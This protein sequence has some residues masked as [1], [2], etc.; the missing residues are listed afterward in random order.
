MTLR[1][2]VVAFALVADAFAADVPQAVFEGNSM[3]PERRLEQALRQYDVTLNDDVTSADDAAFFLREFYF[4]HGFRDASVTYDFSPRRVVFQIDEGARVW[5][6]RVRFEGGEALTR[7]RI[8]AVFSA[9]VRQE[10]H[11]PFGRLAYVESATAAGADRVR[12]TFVSEGFLDAV[13]T[14][15]TEPSLARD[16]VDVLV[17]ID[18]GIRYGIRSVRVEGAPAR[19]D[20]ALE[21]VLSVFQN[22]PYRPGD[23][24]LV[25]MRAADFL[26]SHGF[27]FA[28]ATSEALHGSG[29]AVDIVVRTVPGEAFRIGKVTAEG[30]VRTR[31][32]SLLQR[33]GIRPGSVFNASAIES[34]ERRLWFSG[35]FS[36]V[37]L[38]P[39]PQPDGT[40][41]L[42][43]RVEEGRARQVAT[44][45][46]YSQWDRGFADVLF[47]DRNFLGTL[48]R[49]SLQGFVSQRSYGGIMTLTQPSLFGDET[50]GRFS[51]FAQ[52]RELPAYRAVQY[53]GL[54]GID[55][56]ANDKTLTGWGVNYE[57]R[58][59]TD[60][61]IFSGSEADTLENYRLGMVSFY[62]QLDRR[63][64]VL[65]PMRG[66]NLRYE[67]GVAS[68]ALAGD[69]SFFKATAL[70]T[71]YLP[72]R[73]VLPERPYV[74]F[75]M[76][77]H[78]AG[79]I[80]PF[81]NTSSIPVPERFFLGG[82]DSVRSFQLDGMAPRD[83]D[84]DPT[85][86]EIFFQVNVEYQHPV[87]Q[88]IFAAVFTD[89]GNLSS[90]VAGLAWSDTRVA[91]GAGL[92]LYTPLGT[93]RA[94]YAFN[95][96]RKDGDPV[97]NWQ[98]GLGFTF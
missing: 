24:M 97:G 22:K 92:R 64:D 6:G 98:F 62:Q 35:A 2:T 84:G 54:V 8:E 76:L 73:E 12:Q 5:L 7:D 78:R 17:T 13:V 51:V 4:E 40:V 53:G 61:E 83:R 55:A 49:F 15:T 52:R 72:L 96:V 50:E 43:L 25:R 57:W 23:E 41:N 21:K 67:L 48:N 63:N 81:G 77:N 39:A 20:A 85:G 88:G 42:H 31:P 1:Q 26:R 68:P 93:V 74:P 58:V 60:T 19:V 65:A 46:G 10:M 34:G 28:A 32:G 70:A 94:D 82:P 9:A 30:T 71:W 3:F 36:D 59:I 16:S 45:V 18:Q 56:R 79:V 37:V 38:E 75:F 27:F 44:T 69:V 66:Y 33:F 29:G 91:P 87:W 11:D 95:L 14:C 86:G 80:I 90:K 89:F 47:V